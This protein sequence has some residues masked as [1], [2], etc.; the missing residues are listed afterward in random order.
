VLQEEEKVLLYRFTR[1]GMNTA[2]Y[3]KIQKN[4]YLMERGNSKI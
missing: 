1:S 2:A 4:Y 3:E